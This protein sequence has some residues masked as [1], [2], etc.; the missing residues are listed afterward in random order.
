MRCE[1]DGTGC[2]V[3]EYRFPVGVLCFFGEAWRCSVFCQYARGECVVSARGCGG[4]VGRFCCQCARG[5]VTKT[6]NRT[7]QIKLLGVT[8]RSPLTFQ[9]FLASASALERRKGL[10]RWMRIDII[11]KERD[12][13]LTSAHAFGRLTISTYATFSSQTHT[14]QAFVLRPCLRRN[15]KP[16]GLRK[17]AEKIFVSALGAVVLRRAERARHRSK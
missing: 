6:I 16:L 14:R 2:G 3:R 1:R 10:T 5:A 11:F 7:A 8:E 12:L 17:F 4:T 15:G 9:I 13:P